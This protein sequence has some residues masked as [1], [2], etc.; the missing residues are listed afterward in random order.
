LWIGFIVKSKEHKIYG[1]IF[2]IRE[3]LDI[4][5]RFLGYWKKCHRGKKHET[6]SLR[7]ERV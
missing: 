6:G 5:V 7:L 3:I 4:I 2:R 1:K